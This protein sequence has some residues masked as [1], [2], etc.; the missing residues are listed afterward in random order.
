[1]NTVVDQVLNIVQKYHIT[2]FPSAYT[3]RRIALEEGLILGDFPFRGRIKEVFIRT[4]D[5]IALLTLKSGLPESELKHAFAH[6]LGHFFFHKDPGIYI[7]GILRTGLEAQ[8]EDFA[9]LLLVPPA[10]LKESGQEIPAQE[11]AR[12]AQIPYRLACRRIALARRYG[13]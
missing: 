13:V 11:I 2:T 6:G 8:A 12:L 5:G 4:S 7:L 9:A 10:S 3:L 1:M